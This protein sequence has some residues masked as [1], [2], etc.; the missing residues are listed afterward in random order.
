M[1][2]ECDKLHHLRICRRVAYS[3][4]TSTNQFKLPAVLKANQQYEEILAVRGEYVCACVCVC[5]RGRGPAVLGCAG[6][7][8]P[9]GGD[10]GGPKSE[11]H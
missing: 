8:A 9:G 7:G 10:R 6:V 11:V 1:Y 3:K 5:V 4:G 2:G